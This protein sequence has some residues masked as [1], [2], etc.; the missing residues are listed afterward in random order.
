MFTIMRLYYD[1]GNKVATGQSFISETPYVIPK[2][3]TYFHEEN[4]V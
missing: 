4:I 2:E 1:Y 3:I